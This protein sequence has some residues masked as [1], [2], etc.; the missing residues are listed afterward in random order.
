MNNLLLVGALCLLAAGGAL[1]GVGATEVDTGTD[2]SGPNVCE[3][4]VLVTRYIFRNES[5]SCCRRYW[6]SQCYSSSEEEDDGRRH[7]GGCWRS[8]RTTCYTWRKFCVRTYENVRFCCRGYVKHEGMCVR[9][10]MCEEG[11]GGCE[12]QCSSSEGGRGMCSC[13]PGYK[14]A[15]DGKTCEDEN[16]CLSDNGGCSDTCINTLGS[17]YCECSDPGYRLGEDRRTCED[18]DECSYPDKCEHDCH[19]KPG[20]FYC[21]CQPGFDL[22]EGSICRDADECADPTYNHMCDGLCINDYGGFHCECPEGQRLAADNKTCLAPA[23]VDPSAPTPMMNTERYV[24]QPMSMERKEASSLVGAIAGGVVGA[25]LLLALLCLLL[26]CCWRRGCCCFAAAAV[27]EKKHPPEDNVYAN[28]EPVQTAAFANATYSD[29]GEVISSRKPAPLPK[30]AQVSAGSSK[31]A[32]IEAVYDNPPPYDNP[33]FPA[34]KPPAYDNQAY[35]NSESV[36]ENHVKRSQE[37]A[38]YD[39]PGAIEKEQ[40]SKKMSVNDMIKRFDSQ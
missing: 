14:L 2:L 37:T 18:I 25:L 27:V 8:E 34:G 11:N 17:F 38:Q 7:W 40:V 39:N 15:E 33:A 13:W 22:L 20:S 10:V 32:D 36:Y 16:E 28:V 24:M 26:F 1:S 5:Y 12:Q 23:T 3:R 4:R 9:D 30:P 31:L 35:D 29:P 6:D 21:T 19:N